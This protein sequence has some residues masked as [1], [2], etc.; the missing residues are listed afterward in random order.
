[1][2]QRAFNKASPSSQAAHSTIK[3]DTL[4]FHPLA[5]KA[6]WGG[7]KADSAPKSAL[8][9]R[10]R[11]SFNHVSFTFVKTSFSL[12]GMLGSVMNPRYIIFIASAR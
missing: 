3:A 4:R 1:M 12:P 6:A 7:S 8:E 5:A 11:G 10:M 9:I 2:S